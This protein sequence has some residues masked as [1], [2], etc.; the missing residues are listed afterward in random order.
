VTNVLHFSPC[1]TWSADQNMEKFIEVCRSE[2]KVFGGDLDFDADVWDVTNHLDLKGK[3]CRT[4]VSFSMWGK[5]KG[6]HGAPMPEPFKSFCKA[7]LRY[8]EGLRP[9]KSL[10]TRISALRALCLA[11][12][13]EGAAPDP[14]RLTPFHFN[15]AAQLIQDRL[16]A[17][18]SYQ[19]GVQ[20]ELVSEM[21]VAAGL[22]RCPDIWRCH[23]KRY[24]GHEKVGEEF[25]ARRMAKLPSP[26]ALSAVASIFNI[27]TD[28]SDIVV[29]SAMAILCSAPER[30]NEVL[31]LAI[32][33]EVFQRD[34]AQSRDVYGLRWLPSKGAAPQVK[35]VIG[36]MAE[37]V[38]RSVRKMR[39]IGAP[40]RRIAEWYEA[41][42]TRLF[43]LDEFE[44]LREKEFLTKEELAEVIFDQPVARTVAD[45]WRRNHKLN[46]YRV[47]GKYC[48]SFDEVERVILAML[49]ENFP[50]SDREHGLRYSEML[51]LV[52][53]NELHASRVTYRCMFMRLG[54]GDINVRLTGKSHLAQSIFEKHGFRERNGAPIS[55]TTHNI[56][57]YLNTLAQVGAMSQLD[58]AAWSGRTR[59]SE[60][61]V[62]DHVSN[63]DLLEMVRA[64]VGE[65]D[66]AV[67]PLA[68][69]SGVQLIARNDFAKRK[70]PTAHTTDL[71][72]CL[73]D[74]SLLP[75]QAHQ[76]CLNCNE[77]ICVKGEPDKEQRLRQLI[78][79]TQDLLLRAEQA[80][81]EKLAGAER[82]VTHQKLTVERAEELL[83]IL[84]D[85]CVP[86]G[87]VVSI[88]TPNMPSRLSMAV[89]EHQKLIRFANGSGIRSHRS[90]DSSE[91]TAQ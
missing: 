12:M 39:D 45:L 3:R 68:R 6:E 51:F 55:M 29:M 59:V 34:L 81:E 37:V 87:A 25:D 13:E 83:S 7:Y 66:K 11:L 54:T 48:V 28:P 32:D 20:L 22:L 61:S 4:G 40:A 10:A 69:L 27:A 72:Y 49:P 36:S 31:R 30:V 90:G 85:P 5:R 60:N 35:W 57:H 42:P 63:H 24:E 33:A 41:N 64:A 43:L 71:G 26:D 2:L 14:T 58:I 84:E 86:G 21:M 9:T 75:C 65:P 16:S 91:A 47:G 18:S 88:D 80:Y 74:F 56:R 8:Q 79:E 89:K 78:A 17:T 46:N 82:W 44:Y 50:I 53:R 38:Q 76:D 15:R 73:H 23:I 67:G 70:V 62:Y 52:R 77:H 1:L 19:Y